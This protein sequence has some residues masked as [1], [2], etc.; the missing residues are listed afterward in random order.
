MCIVLSLASIYFNS[1]LAYPQISHKSV[2][3]QRHWSSF[4]V[5]QRKWKHR[6]C[7]FDISVLGLG[8]NSFYSRIF[9]GNNAWASHLRS[10]CQLRCLTES[11]LP[12]LRYFLLCSIWSKQCSTRHHVALQIFPAWTWIDATHNWANSNSNFCDYFRLLQSLFMDPSHL[13]NVVRWAS[14]II[15]WRSE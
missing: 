15:K 8:C 11:V 3:R 5:F 14:C 1:V 12:L 9:F 13:S 10:T 4:W 2:S 6:G 7:K